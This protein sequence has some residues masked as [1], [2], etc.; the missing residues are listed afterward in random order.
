MT[1]LGIILLFS[2][3]QTMNTISCLGIKGTIIENYKIVLSKYRNCKFDL[4]IVKCMCEFCSL[5][6]TILR[7]AFKIA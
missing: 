6:C 3:K 4:M 2:C 7:E 1:P 5:M